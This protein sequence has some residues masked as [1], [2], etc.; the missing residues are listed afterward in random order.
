M[1]EAVEKTKLDSLENPVLL[2]PPMEDADPS[3]T[4]AELLGMDES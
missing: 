3:V 2:L 1:Y 4:E